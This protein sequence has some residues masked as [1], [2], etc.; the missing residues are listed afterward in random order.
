MRMWIE[1]DSRIE[2]TTL[3]E[4]WRL[5]SASL[6]FSEAVAW[7]A[8]SAVRLEQ[9]SRILLPTA[10]KL[11]R[12]ILEKGG[13]GCKSFKGSPRGP[14]KQPGG[15]QTVSTLPG[16]SLSTGGVHRQSS[17]I[18]SFLLKR[19]A[20]FACNQLI[21]AEVQAPLG[22]M[23]LLPLGLPMR[24]ARWR[25]VPGCQRSQ[26]G[27]PDSTSNCASRFCALFHSQVG[28]SALPAAPALGWPY[29]ELCPSR[30]SAPGGC[31]SHKMAIA[32]RLPLQVL[33]AR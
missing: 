15:A 1:S 33:C 25:F 17:R 7:S 32:T 4:R 20:C 19:A 11:F 23:E 14:A 31:R 6:S 28:G 18:L 9:M 5:A 26:I 21:P 27:S 16:R 13:G 29:V 8:T 24:S 12:K 30:A 10:T 3:T 22:T 2:C